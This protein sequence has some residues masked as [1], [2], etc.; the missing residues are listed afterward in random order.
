M[1]SGKSATASTWW[2][3]TFGEQSRVISRECR[4]EFET[5][6]V[7]YRWHPL[8]GQ[9]LI[10]RSRISRNGERVLCRLPDGTVCSLPTWILRPESSQF[11]LGKPRVSV[12]ALRELRDLLSAVQAS[13]GCGMASLKVVPKE[14]IHETAEAKHAATGSTASAAGSASSEF[15]GAQTKRPRRRTSGTS[16]EG[17]RRMRRQPVGKETKQ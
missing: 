13:T 15:A 5:V 6:T 9:K 3:V 11:T 4:R 8:A 17:R 1:R 10:V 16:V 14:G 12:D 7:Y 2:W